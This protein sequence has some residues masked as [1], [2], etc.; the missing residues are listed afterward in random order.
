MPR[1]PRLSPAVQ[2]LVAP[3]QL[4]RQPVRRLTPAQVDTLTQVVRTP[5]RFDE[6]VSVPRAIS[7]LA[8]G[9]QPDAA[10][11][12][13]AQVLGGKKADLPSRIVAA[14][15]LTLIATPAAERALWR[16]IGDPAP[17][18]QQE[19]LWGLGALGGR[20]ALRRLATLPVPADRATRRQLAFARA[21]IAHRHGVDGSS[22]PA[23]DGAPRR[24]EQVGARTSLT[25]TLQTA[26]STAKDAKRLEGTAYGIALGAR[27]LSVECGAAWTLFLNRELAP[28]TLTAQLLERPH[29]LG[30]MARRHAD[31]PGL[32]VSHVLLATPDGDAVRLDVVRGDGERIYTG[33]ATVEGADL[34]FT[35]GDVDRPGTAPA[36]V[37]GRLAP[38]SIDITQAAVSS[39][40]VRVRQTTAVPGF[41]PA[42]ERAGLQ[43]ADKGVQP[44]R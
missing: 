11:P 26:A 22:L 18:V 7:A 5:D 37:A 2:R 17:R 12:V 43:P 23:A 27:S 6:P 36:Y 20:S 41:R 32:S 1:Q 16:G 10:V 33:R 34:R 39:R 3:D 40:R 30:L 13:L 8:R 4:Y 38:R 14:T 21:L 44:W 42:I 24:P 19:V 35:L 29:V 31:R 28:A 15:E 25:V 9:A